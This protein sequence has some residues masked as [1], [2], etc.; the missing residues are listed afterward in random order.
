MTIDY[1]KLN[2]QITKQAV[3][4]LILTDEMK[5]RL[6]ENKLERARAELASRTLPVRTER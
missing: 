5:K 3:G 6:F 1:T 2:Q 4:N